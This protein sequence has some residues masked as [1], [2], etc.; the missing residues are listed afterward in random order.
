M[1]PA[2]AV[3][4]FTR[5]VTPVAPVDVATI[6]LVDESPLCE[7]VDLVALPADLLFLCCIQVGSNSARKKFMEL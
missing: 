6:V 2:I 4:S 5:D 7:H 3:I 1:A